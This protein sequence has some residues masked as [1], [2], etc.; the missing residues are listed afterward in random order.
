MEAG[1]FITVH[2]EMTQGH[3]EWIALGQAHVALALIRKEKEITRKDCNT[4][5]EETIHNP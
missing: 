2:Q 5:N 3:F 1:W 4:S